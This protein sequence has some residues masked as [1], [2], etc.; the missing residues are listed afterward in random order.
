MGVADDYANESWIVRPESSDLWQWD[1]LS[2]FGVERPADIEHKVLT[3]GFDFDA[4][5]PDLVCPSVDL[6]LHESSFT[7][8]ATAELGICCP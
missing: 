4:T 2:S 5:A 1:D 7:V 3:S 6:D 8:S